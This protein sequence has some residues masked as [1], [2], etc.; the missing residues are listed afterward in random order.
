MRAPTSPFRLACTAIAALALLVAPA[1]ALAH[2]GS[3]ASVASDYEAHLTGVRPAV[4]GLTTAVTG[5]DI[6]LVLHVPPGQT[7]V[8]LGVEGEPFLRFHGGVVFANERSPTAG[9]ARVITLASSHLNGPPLWR[10]VHRGLTFRWHEQRLRPAFATHD[11]VAASI[12]IPLQV[13]GTRA[14][15]VGTSSYAR[16]PNA[17]TWVVPLL[18]VALAAGLSLRR[19]RRLMPRLALVLGCIAVTSVLL[20]VVGTTLYEP[21]SSL[22][23]VLEIG[24]AALLGGAAL[25]ALALVREAH[26]AFAATIAGGLAVLFAA[27]SLPVLTHGYA[28]SRLPGNLARAA[29][30]GA[31]AAGGWLLLLG[32]IGLYEQASRPRPPAPRVPARRAG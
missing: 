6:D 9:S 11:G 18:V 5:G 12:A 23:A 15:L 4:S 16:A 7:I 27:T 19:R 2:R 30:I 1:S 20:S 24:A 22:G 29:A 25:V 28:L 26:R 32:A 14:T 13:D 17:F 8:V 10:E 21:H 3:P 31:I